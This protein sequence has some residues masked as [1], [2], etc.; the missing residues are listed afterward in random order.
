M[1]PRPDGPWHEERVVHGAKLIN[2]VEI[3]LLIFK[4]HAPATR[5]VG[6]N[7]STARHGVSRRVSRLKSP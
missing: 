5:P 1:A 2:N 6:K 4:N 3:A 7:V